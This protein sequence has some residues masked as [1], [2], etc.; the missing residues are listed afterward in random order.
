MHSRCTADCIE[1]IQSNAECCSHISPVLCFSGPPQR[2][3]AHSTISNFLRSF[4][5][6][7]KVGRPFLPMN[8]PNLFLAA[9]DK[10]R[11]INQS[12]SMARHIFSDKSENY[13][14]SQI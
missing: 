5:N 2:L 4:I 14:N 13:I 8:L 7:N 12:S 10:T 9:E 3:D 11:I 6:S 1:K